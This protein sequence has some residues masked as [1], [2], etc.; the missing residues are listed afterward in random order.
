[1]RI[2]I[3]TV[4]PLL[5]LVCA[6]AQAEI[7]TDSYGWEDGFGTICGFYGNLGLAENVGAP[8]PVHSGDRSLHL[9]EEPI[10]GTPQAYLAFITGL[11]DGDIIDASFWRFDDSPG[12]SPS[13]RIWA[14]YATSDDINSYMG[15]A[16]GNDDYGPGEGWDQTG[17]Q[18]VFDSDAG[19]RDAL[20]IEC[21]LYSPSEGPGDLFWVDDL[22]VQVEGD[23]L[24]GVRIYN[25]GNIPAPGAV[26]LLALAGLMGR[27]T[28]RR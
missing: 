27:R 26:V 18:W 8:D 23:D 7:I 4:L 28:R 19:A 12:A 1:M 11:Q 2:C 24:S 5:G 6:S 20:V 15:S 3:A 10:E 13:V 25:P 14:H 22:F 17:W 9:V 21:R 16:G